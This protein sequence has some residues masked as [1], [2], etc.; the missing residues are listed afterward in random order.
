MNIIKICSKNKIILGANWMLV[1]AL[2][3]SSVSVISSESNSP[4]KERESQLFSQV[5]EKVR[6]SYV[7]VPSDYQLQ[8]NSIKG[9]LGNL[10]PHSTYLDKDEY[11]QLH[12]KTSGNA[13]GLGIDITNKSLR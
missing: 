10:D 6:T 5:L 8:E 3:F 1:A 7:D 4:Q 2:S 11:K 12:N 9:L 13:G